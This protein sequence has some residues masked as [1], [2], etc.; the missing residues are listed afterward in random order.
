MTR[1]R[2]RPGRSAPLGATWDGG[3]VNMALFSANADAVELCLFDEAGR[4]EIERVALPERTDEVF[5]GY[6][7]DLRPGQLY[8]V[9]VHGPW[10]PEAG[11]RFNPHKLLV[12]PYAK[13]LAGEIR[14]HDA[15]YGYR[16]GHRR[17][18]LAMDRR[19]SAR[20]MPKCVVVDTAHSWGGDQRPR[21]CWA[22]TV[23][24][25]AHVKGMTARRED[26][27][28]TLRGT[29]A[30][31][32]EPKVIEHLAALGVTAVE[33][34]PVHA[35]ADDRHLVDKGL[36]NYWG[37]NTFGFFAPAPRYAPRGDD[38]TEFKLMVRRLHDVGIEVI[39]DVVYNHTAEGNH[40]G[41]TLS[42]R[43]LDNASYYVLGDDPRYY[44]D[45]TGCGNTVNLRHPRVLQMVMD[46]LRY[47]VEECHVDG[48]RFDLATALTR[49]RDRVDFASPFMDAV[50][51]DPVLS[52]VKLIA[53]SWD[54]GPDGYQ[55]GGFPPG[56]S[57][58]NG[59][60][61][62]DVR[63][64]WRGEDGYLAGMASNLL[65]S[66]DIFDRRSRRPSASVNFATAHDG[67][68]LMDLWS[69][70]EKRNA[71]NGEDGR[72]GHDDNRS[73]NCGAEGPTEDGAV[74]A[75]R[76]RLRRA[77]MA[78]LLLSQGTPMLL[79][80]DEL[81]RSQGGNNNAY[82]QD[83][84][85][86][87]MDW[88]DDDPRKAAFLAFTKGVIGLRRAL[89]LLRSD[90]YLHAVPAWEDGPPQAAW[91]RP[92]GGAMTGEDWGAGHA[93]A[94]GLALAGPEGAQL[95]ML[96]NAHHEPIAFE[97]PAPTAH[98]AWRLR[99][100]SAA[101]TIDPPRALVE[102]GAPFEAPGRGVLLLEAF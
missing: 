76:D 70:D 25:E 100:D 92:D 81:G 72:D 69:Y 54:I 2:I 42:L 68:T 65:G 102:G 32:A 87:W 21:R 99:L 52:D 83:N 95:L 40:L 97:I 30:G 44:F 14:W 89:P 45:T 8:G 93:R 1:N 34:M 64:F 84:E 86:A 79:M 41:P 10:A 46:S 7:P 90:R 75:L 82:C 11:H 36:S 31:L 22:D 58:W 96:V 9:R 85:I 71:A 56:W 12:D 59:R 77:T 74:L 60:W 24:Y 53:E 3:G 26:I 101:G 66:A 51:Q 19:D 78:T 91:L 50:R 98:G 37:Y 20:C 61:R 17:E 67:F 57:E 4:K 5:H 35:F 63:S 43:G 15:V 73:W 28:E 29:F 47:W 49:D 33:L 13:A 88:S 55:V 38:R 18:D 23:I 94:V 62:D 27:P 48:F 80:G 39:L 16:I 6:F